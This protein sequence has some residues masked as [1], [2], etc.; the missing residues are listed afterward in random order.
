MRLSDE[1]HENLP[2]ENVQLSLENIGMFVGNKGFGSTRVFFH[3]V[4]A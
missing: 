1:Y 4:T 3:G 2:S